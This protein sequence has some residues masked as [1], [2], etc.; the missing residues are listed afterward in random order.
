MATVVAFEFPLE[1]GECCFSRESEEMLRWC[2]HHAQQ[3][4]VRMAQHQLNFAP[5]L[6][7]FGEE[8]FACVNLLSLNAKTVL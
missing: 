4:S 8:A 3:H 7:C 5:R 2:S 1:A 6:M